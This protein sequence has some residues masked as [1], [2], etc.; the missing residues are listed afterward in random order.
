[1]SVAG[2][3]ADVNWRKADISLGMSGLGGK[4]DSL[5]HLS[6]CPLVAISGLTPVLEGG[7]YRAHCDLGGGSRPP[8]QILTLALPKEVEHWLLTTLPEMLIKIEA[9]VVRHGRYVTF[10]LAEVAVP[11]NLFR[12]SLSLIDDLGPRPAPA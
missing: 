2:G 4:A 7:R 5:A 8:H 1:M 9:K 10:Q 11:R 6:A 12:K 3:R